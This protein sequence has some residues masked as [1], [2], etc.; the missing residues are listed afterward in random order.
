MKTEVLEELGL[1][2]GEI[3]VYLALSSLG[4]ST[5]GPIARK[6]GISPSKVYIVL[7][8]LIDKSLVGVVI[9][10]RTKHFEAGSP[11]DLM[12]I[13]RDKKKKIIQHE[14]EM[15]EL[16]NQIQQTTEKKTQAFVY[17]G[18][19]AVRNLHNEIY[20]L[21]EKGDEYVVYGIRGSEELRTLH[22]FF[23]R[24]HPKR[25]KK[26]VPGKM[27]YEY[28]ARDVAKARAKLPLTKVKVLPKSFNTPAAIHL[29]RDRTSIILFSK[30]TTVVQI[31]SKEVA[32]SFREY[33]KIIWK[34]A[35][36][37]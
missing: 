23:Q 26:G 20:E 15:R 17:S 31:E 28:D 7:N 32:E 10:G 3:N 21:M 14:K 9:E 13:L 5:S 18:L 24:W 36:S 1:T 4:K 19:G 34:L 33:F 8:K 29:F 16:I 30:P 12:G 11:E 2:K 6:A 22:E 35:K 25:A 27:I 37:V